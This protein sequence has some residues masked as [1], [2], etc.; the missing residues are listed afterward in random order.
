MPPKKIL[1]IE[2]EY[3]VQEAIRI[4][5][6]TMA[7]WT[8]LLANSG[9]EGIEIAVANPPDA[10]LLDLMMPQLDG[11]QTF[12]RLQTHPETRSIPVILMTARFQHNSEQESLPDGITALIPKPFDPMTLVDQISAALG[13]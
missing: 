5:L 10:I 2:D 9:I 3:R 11:F 7:D 6:E 13:W 12:E 1:L 8:I 4:T